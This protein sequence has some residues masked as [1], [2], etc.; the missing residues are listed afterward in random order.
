M[1]V[2]FLATLFLGGAAHHIDVAGATGIVYELLVIAGIV[3]G[4]VLAFKRWA[5]KHLVEP[6]RQVPKVATDLS[7]TNA[8]LEKQ[9]ECLVKQGEALGKL[10]EGQKALREGQ[11]AIDRRMD[12]F[13][14]EFQNNGGHSLRDSND[15]TEVIARAVAHYLG[16]EV[17]EAGEP[18]ADHHEV[19]DA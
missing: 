17:P 10:H 1:P 3:F 19:G 6:L 7:A 15:R 5:N 16:L 18:V 13:E 9:G 8:A 2:G 11:E 12:A 4:A 14:S